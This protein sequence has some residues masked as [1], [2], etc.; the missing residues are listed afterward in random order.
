MKRNA[1]VPGWL[2]PKRNFW[3][4]R[5]VRFATEGVSGGM[6]LIRHHLTP[7]GCQCGKPVVCPEILDAEILH[8]NKVLERNGFGHLRGA[9]GVDAAFDLLLARIEAER[10]KTRLVC[11]HD[12]QPGDNTAGG[13]SRR[14]GDG[15]P[16]HGGV[17]A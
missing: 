1:D 6:D 16:L 10:Q 8:V 2:T 14:E 13:V 12:G 9:R 15:F 7:N 5:D 17:A 3:G 4:N 11:V